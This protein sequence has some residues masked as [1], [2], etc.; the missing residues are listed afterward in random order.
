MKRKA[1][2]ENAEKVVY[3]QTELRHRELP[4]LEAEP[5]GEHT[6]EAVSNRIRGTLTH[7]HELWDRCYGELMTAAVA[8]LEQEVIRL[9]G[10][11]A[12]VVDESID[13]RRNDAT[14]EA[15]LHGRFTYVLYQA[16]Q[17]GRPEVET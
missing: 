7:G 5:V 17:K 3:W 6:V 16:A 10:R 12:R 8:R 13:T 14:G 1:V 15:W 2:P 11:Y 4:P 9:S